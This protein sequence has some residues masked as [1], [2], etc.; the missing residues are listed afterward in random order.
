MFGNEDDDHAAARRLQVIEK[1]A[2]VTGETSHASLIRR[3]GAPGAVD[4]IAIVQADAVVVERDSRRRIRDS[5]VPPVGQHRVVIVNRRAIEGVLCDRCVVVRNRLGGKA[6]MHPH[7][8]EEISEVTVMI[9]QPL[10]RESH[11]LQA[12]DQQTLLLRRL[13]QLPL[14]APGRNWRATTESPRDRYSSHWS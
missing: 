7:V 12:I 14:L 13:V 1:P 6:S 5:L 11:P 8:A 9:H 4:A 3:T 10:R 2:N